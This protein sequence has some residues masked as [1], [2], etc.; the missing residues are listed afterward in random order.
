[1][2]RVLVVCNTGIGR[3]V[4][5][6]DR[7]EKTVPGNEYS[8]AALDKVPELAS[9][10]DVILTFGSLLA[11]VEKALKDAGIEAKIKTVEGFNLFAKD[12]FNEYLLKD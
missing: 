5:L 7:L 3:S 10:Y 4:M 1:M 2:L 9:G 12:L 8:T 11:W 6:K